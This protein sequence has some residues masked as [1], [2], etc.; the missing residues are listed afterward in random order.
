MQARLIRSV[1]LA[2]G[3]NHFVFEA[4][5]M[6]RL[7]F[8]PG[9]FVSFEAEIEGKQITRAYSIASAPT[10]HN[11]FELCLNRVEGGRLS[12]H[13]FAMQPGDVIAMSAPLGTFT[14]RSPARDS[15]LIATGTGVAPFRS[16]LRAFLP[17][18]APGFTLLFGIRYEAHILYRVEFEDLEVR[19]PQ[20][21]FWPT[22]SRAGEGW[23]G[24]RGHV[25]AHLQEAIA[26]RTDVDFYL[27]GLKEMV[28]DVRGTLKEMGFERK[29]IRYEKYD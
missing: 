7:E 8:I 2:E 19:Y 18:G 28:D 15:I 5:G 29:Q 25:Q 9:Q 11:R 27:C 4:V 22:L 13:L 21:Q 10:E 23:T 1:E 16:I 12:P 20:F 24:R 26:G 6:E 3:V 17:H 14:M